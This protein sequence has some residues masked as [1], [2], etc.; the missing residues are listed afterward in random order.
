LRGDSIRIA[1]HL[2]NSADDIDALVAGFA[3]VGW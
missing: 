2:H 3:K 1:P